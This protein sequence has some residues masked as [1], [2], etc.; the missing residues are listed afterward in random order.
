MPTAKLATI[1][2]RGPA[3]VEEL[4][5]DGHGRI[6]D[7][8]VGAAHELEDRGPVG[9]EPADPQLAA[10]LEP[11]DARVGQDAARSRRSACAIHQPPT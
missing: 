2:S 5:V 4:V 10:A 11:L 6:R 8:R 1:R 7:H 9:V 3:G